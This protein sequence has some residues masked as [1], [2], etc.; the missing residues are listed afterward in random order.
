M[1][2]AMVELGLNLYIELPI[3]YADTR[4]LVKVPSSKV[5]H[6]FIKHLVRTQIYSS[7]IGIAFLCTIEQVVLVDSRSKYISIIAWIPTSID[8]ASMNI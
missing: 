5:N 3:V 7:Y 8:L 2:I 6:N 1:Y 4:Y